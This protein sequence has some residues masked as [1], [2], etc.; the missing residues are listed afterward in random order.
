[1][2]R[3]DE[4]NLL[5]ATAPKHV[6]LT[7]EQQER[8]LMI[9]GDVHGC[10]DELRQLIREHGDEKDLIIFV[11]DMTNKGPKSVEVVQLARQLNALA[12]IG[13]H[14]LSSLRGYHERNANPTCANNYEWTDELLA[15]DISYLSRLPYTISIPKHNAVVVHAGLVLGVSLSQQ[16]PRDM[17]AMRNVKQ[18][19]DGSWEAFEQ[20]T[21]GEA[22]A[23]AWK[24]PQHVYFGHDAKR[25]L[26]QEEF[27]TGLDS[28]CLY[29]GDLTA[30]LIRP[31]GKKKLVSVRSHGSY[32][33]PPSGSEACCTAVSPPNFLSRHH[34]VIPLVTCAAL[35]AA[36]CW[37]KWRQPRNSQTN[38]A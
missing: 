35:V 38:Q 3:D 37:F 10:S 6:S 4:F 29:G 17:V 1:M 2:P 30:V 20:T 12:V 31:D 16:K 24:G 27:A 8:R 34:V 22:W 5:D 36:V 33:R 18:R 9:V 23:K 7:V 14:E 15:E 19:E 13:N 26:Q 21:Q 25:R 28:G 32:H 11:G